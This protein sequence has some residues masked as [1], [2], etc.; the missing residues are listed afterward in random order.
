MTF[1]K[2][3]ARALGGSLCVAMA[4]CGD[5][6]PEP[7]S[8]DEV[9]AHV[10]AA[11]GP[12]REAFDH[13][14]GVISTESMPRLI[15][16]L[17]AAKDA[18]AYGSGFG[19]APPASGVK[20]AGVELVLG[21]RAG[22]FSKCYTQ[23]GTLISIDYACVTDGKVRGTA[24][25]RGAQSNGASYLI[26]RLLSICSTGAGGEV[27][28]DGETLY[29]ISG[30]QKQ[31][32]SQQDVTIR[33]PN[34]QTQKAKSLTRANLNPPVSFRTLGWDGDTSFVI[35]KGGAYGDSGTITLMGSNGSWKCTFTGGGGH[36]SCEAS[37]QPIVKW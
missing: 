5:S 3:G 29:F 21:P 28:M 2:W 12:A 15:A 37:G 13:P 24:T 18:S 1:S 34:G 27:C 33:L 7:G 16:S 9:V 10:E 6:G 35:E 20:P 36:G 8:N 32:D 4:A 19:G 11:L 23:S 25:V 30:D 22:D 17:R 14:S 26:V 31:I